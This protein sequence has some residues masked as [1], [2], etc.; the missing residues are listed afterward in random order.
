MKR[1]LIFMLAVL[2]CGVVAMGQT[3]QARR[4]RLPY[5]TEQQLNRPMN[6]KPIIVYHGG[7]IM[8]GPINLYVVY[9]GRFTAK[10]HSILDTF[11]EH[12]GGSKAFNVTTG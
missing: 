8:A 3:D 4:S 10:Q 9:Y 5:A 6:W 2:C 12:V 7:P 11:L 1:P